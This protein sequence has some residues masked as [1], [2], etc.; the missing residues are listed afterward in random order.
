M[1]DDV[2]RLR[3]R[4]QVLADAT[5]ELA[6]APDLRVI[7]DTI[8]HRTADLLG[9]F[10]SI[11]MLEDGWVRPA[12]FFHPVERV[13][14]MVAKF[15]ASTPMPID[16]EL[17]PAQVIR[18]GR[19][20]LKPVLDP[21]P[22]L[23][24]ASHLP[25]DDLAIMASIH[26]ALHVPVTLDDRTIGCLA[27]VRMGDDGPALDE[28]D[29]VLAESLAQH[30]AIAIGRTRAEEVLRRT[31]A[32]LRQ[33]LKM[34]AIGRLAGGIAH[35]FNNMLSVIL[36]YAGLLRRADELPPRARARLEEIEKAGQRAA[37]LTRQ[38][39]AFSR[40]QV[41]E[42]RALDVRHMVA[43][44]E[45]ML[46][47]IVGED[48]AIELALGDEPAPTRAD[49]SQL[50]Q[51]ILNLVVNA[52]DAMPTGGALTIGCR[53]VAVPV[54]SDLPDGNYVQLWVADTGIGMDATTL[55][56]VFEPFF[57]TKEQGRGTGLGLA[58]VLG[59]TQQTGG[60]VRVHSAPGKGTTFEVYLPTTDEP[61]VTHAPAELAT[62]DG[63]ETVLL[64]EDE[65][66]LRQVA[67]DLLERHGYH[68]LAAR[69][70][71]DAIRRAT[72]HAGPIHLLVTDVV[73]PRM[74]GRELAGH[75]AD[76]RPDTRVLYMSGYTDDAIFHHGVQ[77]AS[78]AFL[79]KPVTP[80]ALLRKVRTV[81]DA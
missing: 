34:E 53:V 23:A 65:D 13:M 44:V 79:P 3:R 68:V 12:A 14:N 17:E 25:A 73:M 16:A 72:A 43:G 49:P 56:H 51:V 78:F 63:D 4:L 28:Q 20:D 22:L 26:T 74:S 40:Q 33:A 62:V 8:V 75:L 46:R 77:A 15:V 21:G 31:E 42:P 35:D 55:E 19:S 50:E 2:D 67:L 29:L 60:A 66:A 54:S 61:V 64:V 71:A 80:D 52:R 37:A 6:A 32:Q 5:R 9:G 70:G 76:L 39:L 11:A 10:C 47:H 27:I 57:T 59:I 30:A 58:T 69:D 41:V 81:L 38:L 7:L 36:S 18:T 48:I 24:F 45:A 1:G